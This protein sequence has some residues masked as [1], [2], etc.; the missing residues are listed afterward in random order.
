MIVSA[1]LCCHE[2]QD[3]SAFALA[4]EQCQHENDYSSDISNRIVGCW[5]EVVGKALEDQ[6]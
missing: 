6:T 5:P 4:N 1:L 2:G 3:A